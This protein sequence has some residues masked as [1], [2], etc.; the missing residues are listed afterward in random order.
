MK[1]SLK[2]LYDKFCT[3]LPIANASREFEECHQLHIERLD[4]PMRKFV[5]RTI[6]VGDRLPKSFQW[7]ALSAGSA[8]HEV[9]LINCITTRTSV[10]QR[11]NIPCRTLLPISI[12]TD[13]AQR[14]A[15]SASVCTHYSCGRC[16]SDRS[17]R[18]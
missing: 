15:P 17:H 18:I 16:I 12:R 14:L 9:W 11:R 4:K 1:D 2:L 13:S 3:S 8:W 6:D 7:T 10:R 5:L